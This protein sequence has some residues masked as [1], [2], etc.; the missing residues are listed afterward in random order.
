MSTNF[1]FSRLE[2]NI[3]MVKTLSYD[4]IITLGRRKVGT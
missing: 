4:V 1:K 3:G 2:S